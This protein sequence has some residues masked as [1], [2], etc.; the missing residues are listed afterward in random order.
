MQFIFLLAF[1]LGLLVAFSQVPDSRIKEEVQK[2]PV[3]PHP[4]L[5]KLRRR[6]NTPG[7]K[8]VK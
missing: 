4:E 6:P 8:S 2:V 3:D 7:L 1:L 5:T